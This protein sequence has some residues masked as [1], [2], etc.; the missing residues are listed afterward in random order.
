LMTLIIWGLTC[1]LWSTVWVFI[2]LGVADVPPVTFA[3]YRLFVAL[4]VLA[5]IT[6]ARRVALPTDR[7]D[8]VLIGGTGVLL[9]GVN[10]AL[11]YWGMQFVSSGLAAVLQ[12]LT[13]VFGMVFAHVLLAH[14]R[15]TGVKV[16]AL[17]VGIV[18]VAVIFA[19]QLRFAGWRSLLGSSAVLAG[20]MFVALAYVLMKKH[21]RDLDPSLITAGQ[22]LAALLP[23]SAFGFIVE[24]SPLAVRWTTT[25]TVALLYLAVFGS[26]TATWLNYWLLKRMDA[27]KV[28]VM[29]LA[30]PPIAMMLGAAILD[31]TL[32]TRMLTGTICIL[33]S[34]GVVLDLVPYR[35]RA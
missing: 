15:I 13:P 32:S 28:L 24:G 26:I 22:M 33:V 6:A 10:Y 12:A 31:E 4:L 23:L 19:D 27:T 16:A 30:E 20:A 2:K 17:A 7:R 11:L 14:E 8:W 25:A 3:A 34:V 1:A 35:P 18:G 5:P 29:A 9:L 21:G